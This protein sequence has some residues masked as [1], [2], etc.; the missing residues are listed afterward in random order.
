MKK[1]ILMSV[2]TLATFSLIAQSV[3][4]NPNNLQI[5]SVSALPACAAADY[6]K[7]VFLTTTN[8]ANV[9]SGTGWIEVSAGGGGGGSLT[10]PFSGSISS[11]TSPFTITNSGGGAN[12]AGINGIT[13]SALAGASGVWGYTVS[14]TPTGHNYGVYG[15]N[16][17]TNGNGFGVHGR[18][19]GSGV[20]VFGQS[21]SGN[22]VEGVTTT[23]SGVEG[24][25]TNGGQGVLGISTGNA[26][27]IG[28][29]GSISGNL[30]TAVKGFANGT[31]SIAGSFENTNASGLG[32]Q[33]LGKIRFQGNGAGI[34]KVLVSTDANGTAVWESLIRTDVLKLGAAAFQ[35]HISTNESTMGGQGI[36][37]TT[38]AGSFHANVALPNGAALTDFT[39]YYIDNDG[40]AP[41]T[42]LGLTSFAL[43]KLN[44]TGNGGSY[45]NVF[46]GS[47]NFINTPASP[48]MGF[49]TTSPLSEII[50]NN[51]F[52]YRLVVTM[53]AS[54]NLTLV[55]AAIRYSYTLNN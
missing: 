40:V 2:F 31:N 24:T 1:C 51:T 21:V 52:F 17:A 35:S 14:T 54:T 30:G 11:S 49:F 9:C 10:L 19:N 50:D 33:T 20:G 26:N 48:N 32:L 47:G 18:H 41:A 25:S 38:A 7:I 29:A 45:T 16:Q 8:R 27:A 39:I 53:P 37:M 5:P 36:S 23:G 55:G 4:I 6:G 3:S 28:V 15:L 44:H 22:G 42:G 34:D 43:Q 46:A 12:S 13:G